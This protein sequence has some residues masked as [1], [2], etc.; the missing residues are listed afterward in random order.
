MKI[1]WILACAGAL[2]LAGLTGTAGAAAIPSAAAQK[3]QDQMQLNTLKYVNSVQKQVRL[4]I[5][6]NINRKASKCSGGW[7]CA[8]GT[9]NNGKCDPVNGN[10]QCPGGQC[11]PNATKGV[12]GQINKAKGALRAKFAQFCTAAH[13]TELGFPN[14]RCPTANTPSLVADCVLQGAIGDFDDA[15][16][17]DPAGEVMAR[18][19]GDAVPD[20]PATVCAVT[21]GSILSIGS[22]STSK[23]IAEAGGALPLR[24]SSC[25][26]DACITEAQGIIGNN[27]TAPTQT[28]AG[29]IPVCLNTVTGD[30]GNGT[31]QAGTLNIG[32]GVQ[33]SFAPIASTVLIGTTCPT[34]QNGACD[35]GPSMG[36]ECNSPGG[37]DV[38]CLPTMTLLDPVIPNPLDLTTEGQTINVPAHNPSGGVTNPS[39][40][41][42]GGCD[43]HGNGDPSIGCDNDADCNLQG[44]CTGGA[45]CCA[46][47]TNTGAFGKP[48][49]SASATGVRGPYMPRLGTIFCTGSSTD[50]LVDATQG[51]PGPVRLVQQQLNAF[52]W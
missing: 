23:T 24:I 40:A 1:R 46:F 11:A 48:V 3:C 32:T 4:S 34:C 51:L 47:G 12:A 6:N 44:L 15:V 27:L 2:A 7:I 10:S 19:M 38:A 50:G 8:G 37:T 16:F 43:D 49:T 42:C 36:Q 13:L 41:F 22:A 45:G 5:K 17:G 25:V 9:A 28:F 35:S 33:T 18:A 52:T 31:P 29:M 30:A 39:G 26:G 14:S 20:A 21:L